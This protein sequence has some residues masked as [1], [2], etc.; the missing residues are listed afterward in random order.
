MTA[1]SA[2]HPAVAI[3]GA[4]AVL[5][6]SL[7]SISR[8]R[9]A[10]SLHAMLGEGTPSA[11]ALARITED[12]RTLDEL[13]V[14]ASLPP[15]ADA[16]AAPLIGF[17]CRLDEAI[18]RSPAAAG[19]VSHVRWHADP[20]PA[21]FVREL[22]LP[23]GAYYLDEPAWVEFLDR[24]TPE[25]MRRQLARDE[26]LVA[27][28][29][30]AAAALAGRLVRDPLRLLELVTESSD[31]TGI[32][33]D[34]EP[35]HSAERSADG[36]TLLIRI[37]GRRPVGD[38]DFAARFCDTVIHC[39]ADAAPGEL[40]VE[41][42]G[43]Y[44][45]AT[46]T[47]RAIRADS[48]A[49]TLASVGLLH[50]I[51]GV[52]Y[53]RFA[54][55]LMIL[56][57]AALGIV[58]GFGVHALAAPTI[59]PLTAVIAAMLAGLGVDYGIHF[60]SHY[61]SHRASGR[62][63]G[64]AAAASAAHLGL[65]I[66]TNCLT[67]IF[68]FA[69]LWFSGVAMLSDF[70]LLG[71]LGLLGSLAA[72]FLVLPALL[73]L[74]DRGAGRGRAGAVAPPRFGAIARP[75]A[76]RPGLCIAAALALLTTAATGAALN[77]FVPRLEA[78]LT[79]MHPRPNRPLELTNTLSARFAGFGETIPIE[80]TA[81]PEQLTAVAHRAAR[82]LDTPSA[83]AAGVVGTIGLNTLLPDPD[84]AE[85]R[86]RALESLNPDAVVA[87]FDGAIN[88]SIFD[89]GAFGEYRELLRTLVSAPPPSMSGILAY[90]S[91]ASRVFPAEADGP[92]GRTLLAVRLD[93]PL[94]DRARRDAV[95]IGL[96]ETLA[97]VPE[98][99]L[100]GMSV[101]GHDLE[102]ATRA[103]LARSVAISVLLVVLLLALVFRRPGDVALALVPLVFA[104]LCTVAFMAASGARLNPINA[105]ALPLL[106]GIAVDAGVFLVAASRLGTRGR[107]ALA[108]QFRTTGPAVLAAAATTVAGFGALVFTRT[109][110]VQSL[111]LAASLGILAAFVGSLFLLMP[112][113]LLREHDDYSR[114]VRG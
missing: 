25:G 62:P 87:T 45:I 30:P 114:G 110:A 47:S 59:T 81:T 23:H 92:P 29:G 75:A 101:V 89:P 73:V 69:S 80:I 7:V 15:G 8:M 106:D 22:V 53:R 11:A 90:P 66:V 113:L 33:P 54:A 40:T 108:E 63:P 38:L 17:A 6:L 72:A 111:G 35:A 2:A 37:G 64:E 39:A 3:A 79:V 102:R 32:A 5:V 21:R 71:T 10:P 49:S 27:A 100:T 1:W 82:A 78:D 68:G 9:L 76:R 74:A 19:M 12:Y 95:I 56:G 18:A 96:R 83:R 93:A 97:S 24:L 104:L 98:A 103:D 28:P 60:L 34:G 43:G 13:Y 57:V 85:A 109:P 65:P 42:A 16:D 67:S 94:T 36:R 20:E 61:Q 84:A 77:G 58:A 52:L 26:A 31:I 112:L 55:P 46:R 86:R 70:A 88:A 105:V 48:I 99:T 51:F 107:R 41:L 14:L 4:A 44:A 50:L 91:I